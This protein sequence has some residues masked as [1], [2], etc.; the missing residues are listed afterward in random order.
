MRHLFLL[1]ALTALVPTIS[2]GQSLEKS[3]DDRY[4]LL[5]E[6]D[7]SFGARLNTNGW[8]IFGTYGKVVSASKYRF[9]QVELTELRHPKEVKQSSEFFDPRILSSPKPF[10]YGKQNSFFA[11]N[12]SVGRRVIIG[13]K[14]ERS[15]VEVN[16]IYQGGPTLGLAKPYYLEILQDGND[17]FRLTESIAY[18]EENRADFLDISNI[19][20]S[21]GFTK[22]LGEL[23]FYPGV[24]GKTGLN[25]DWANYS[26][27]VTALE[28]GLA[29]NLFLRSVPIMVDAPNRPYFIYLYLGIQFGKKW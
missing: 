29:A 5:Y 17:R 2:F 16:W 21:S 12:F 22:G 13:E 3:G 23:R 8:S 6:E 27:F 10:I 9:Y 18:S 24:H 4:G 11:L 1:I 7:L 15:G 28:V 25:F 14:A 20:G 26:E 19:Y